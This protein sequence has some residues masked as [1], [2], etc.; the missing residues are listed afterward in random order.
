MCKERRKLWTFRVSTS[1]LFGPSIWQNS[2]QTTCRT[3]VNICMQHSK[4]DM[5]IRWWFEVLLPE[6]PHFIHLLPLTLQ[7]FLIASGEPPPVL[8]QNKT[9]R[10][11]NET[12]VALRWS[13]CT[14][15]WSCIIRKKP[16]VKV[17]KTCLITCSIKLKES[18]SERM[19][20][21]C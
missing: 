13:K 18:A 9:S 20:T 17:M 15:R 7:N 2:L 11:T 4:A 12:L 14:Y 10:R 19:K 16:N 5:W 3:T 21:K 6:P 1:A 8:L